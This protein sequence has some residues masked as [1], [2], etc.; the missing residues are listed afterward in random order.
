MDT[1]WPH[2]AEDHRISSNIALGLL[3]FDSASVYVTPSFNLSLFFPPGSSK[4]LGAPGLGTESVPQLQQHWTIFKI[5]LLSQSL[6]HLA[7]YILALAFAHVLSDKH[8]FLHTLWM[9]RQSGYHFTSLNYLL[10]PIHQ[11]PENHRISPWLSH[12]ST[13]DQA[14][15]PWRNI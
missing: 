11:A 13:S 15:S 1:S 10:R 6:C 5:Y 2:H 8:T 14:T 4:A 3:H 12:R 9:S 7:L